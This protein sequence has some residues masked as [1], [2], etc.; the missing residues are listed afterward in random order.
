M[1]KMSRTIIFDSGPIISL[2]LNNLLWVLEELKKEYNGTFIIPESV[3]IELID[4]PFMTKKYK[5]E[6]LQVMK[7]IYNGTLNIVKSS[8]IKNRT[9]EILNIANTTFKAHNSFV[10]IVQEGE[11][12]AISAYK[13]LNAEA[14]VIDERTMRMLIEEPHALKKLMESRLHTNIEV[15]KENFIKLKNIFSGIN[16]IRSTEIATIAYEKKIL[17]TLIVPNEEKVYKNLKIELLE[18]ILWGLKLSG[19]SISEHEINGILRM[20]SRI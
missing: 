20:E 7:E 14:I 10:Q 17:N 19:C 2:T 13:H 5:F 1:I 9:Q 11:I 18:S 8:I 15:N 4:K 16:V 12:E 3:K 6:A